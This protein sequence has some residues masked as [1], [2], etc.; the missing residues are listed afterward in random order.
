MPLS[1]FRFLLAL[2]AIFGAPLAASAQAAAPVTIFVVR[3]AERAST[4]ADSPL[5]EIGKARAE[6]L[7]AM[8]ASAGVAHA[9]STQFI[10]TK[11]TVAPLASRMGVTPVVVG[12]SD[13]N[14][15]ISMLQGLPAGS[16]ALVAGHSNTINVIV[17]RLTGQEIPALEDSVY[18]RLYVV[19]LQGGVGTAVLLHY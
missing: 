5:S 9:I 1:R 11:D 2:L 18:D 19:T 17:G 10:R 15:L 8:L 16:K 12:T 13:M 3:H 4:E 7:A 6:R 14:P